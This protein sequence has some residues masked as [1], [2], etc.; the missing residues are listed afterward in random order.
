MNSW[1]IV[2]ALGWVGTIQ[3]PQGH[4]PRWEAQEI[5]PRA[6]NVVYAVTVADVD[7]DG[8][9]DVVAV[10]EDAVAWYEN[11]SWRR[12]DIVRG[13]TARD[14][15]CI[16]ARDIDGDGQVDF[17]LGAGWR[18]PDT[19]TPGTLQWL[20]RDAAGEWAVHK[21]AYEEPSLH[22]M[23]WADVDGDG[24][25][26]LVV[27]PLQGRG[28]TGPNWGE[29][30]GVKIRAFR[31][32]DDPTAEAWPSEVADDSLHA[33]HNFE[34][35]QLDDDAAEELIVGAWE[36]VFLLDRGADGAW[37]RAKLGE[38]YQGSELPNKGASEIKLGRVGERGVEA[39]ATIEPWHGD[40][41]IVYMR[42]NEKEW[43]RYQVESGVS[44]GH[45]VWFAD[46]DGRPG[47]ELII[48][49]RDP[50]RDDRMPKGPGVRVFGFDVIITD[51]TV[52][53]LPYQQTV[54]DGGMACEDAMAADLD[55]DGRPEII[56]GGRAT[57][58]VKIYWN[59][60]PADAR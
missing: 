19:E 58:N 11:P 51:G 24:T 38:G 54:D 39:I 30:A 6:G 50:R 57:H 27:V 13:V 14:N 21:I 1:A 32:P 17:V 40:R 5:D 29:D 33:A 59:R 37:T 31:V 25:T 23:R 42:E 45:A 15:V 47:Q 28:T 12:R 9:D 60:A 7:G 3:E 48:G 46:L 2:V 52:M 35:V 55:G 16:A 8:R 20:G 53:T 44:W 10:T 49:Q 41:V 34:P 36:G 18:P 43:A 22:R 56:A 26:E 4:W